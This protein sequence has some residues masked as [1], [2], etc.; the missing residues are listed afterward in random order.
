[1]GGLTESWTG[2]PGSGPGASFSAEL[3]AR[4]LYKV[5]W[6]SRSTKQTP[7]VWFTVYKTGEMI[8]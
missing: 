8:R 2:G 4:S 7:T 1:M 6:A 3:A 5:L